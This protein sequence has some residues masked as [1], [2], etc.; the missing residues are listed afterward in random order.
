MGAM[1][2]S[3]SMPSCRYRYAVG[4]LGFNMNDA[5]GLEAE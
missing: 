1:A 2:A 3:T 4:A 5:D